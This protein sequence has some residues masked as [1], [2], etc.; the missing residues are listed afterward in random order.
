LWP[1]LALFAAGQ[2]A[3][4]VYMHTGR[5]WIGITA[6]VLLWVLGDWYLVAKHVYEVEGVPLMLPLLALQVVAVLTVAALLIGQWRRRWSG[7]ARQ[8]TALF[9]TAIAAYLQGNLAASSATLRRLVRND[10]WDAAA[11]VAFGNV[12]L[13]AGKVRRAR[14][15]YRRA[16]GVDTG[17]AFVDF[18]RHQ[19]AA[20]GRMHE[21]AR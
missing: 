9:T 6:T 10:P 7:T 1:N 12:M 17:E 21:P 18:V 13:R 5:R 4:W 20:R 14:R 11:W 2:A 16:L 15:C 3:S 8:R 19:L